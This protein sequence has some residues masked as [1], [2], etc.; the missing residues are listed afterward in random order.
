MSLNSPINIDTCRE[1]LEQDLLNAEAAQQ[2]REGAKEE[3]SHPAVA[4]LCAVC[5]VLDGDASGDATS[6]AARTFCALDR[7]R[8]ESLVVHPR[9]KQERRH[10]LASLFGR[11]LHLLEGDEVA[12]AIARAT[13]KAMP[14]TFPQLCGI[15]DECAKS[16]DVNA[17]EIRIARGEEVMFTVLVDKSPFLCV[18]R[19]FVSEGAVTT[20]LRLSAAE[21][22][23]AVAH[24]LE[25]VKSG[26][27]ALLQITPERLENLILDEIPFLVRTPIKVGSK[28][29]GWTRANK[30]VKKVGSWLPQKSRTQK[31]VNTVGE[32]L[33]D[34]A[35]ET[36]LP[37]VVHDWVRRWI[38][39]VE[40][41]A[42]RAG[43]LLSGSIAASCSAMLRLSPDYAPQVSDI[44]QRGARWLLREK[45][46]VDRATAERLR[47][48]LRFA[49]SEEYLSFVE[50]K[51]GEGRGK[52]G[53]E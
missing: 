47:E 8:H 16:L 34:A 38:Q 37:D 20:S 45:A 28:F 14:Q 25:H 6:F 33:P 40:F 51:E 35:Q 31:V 24:N 27:A 10:R 1:W 39:G 5:A 11:I 32:L 12:H 49:V 42:D 30:A 26:H 22:R 13:E 17:P 36:V 53:R 9:E 7:D 18:H 2:L 21:T 50:G 15:K 52:R 19:D 3:S 46:D 4:A 29:L 48:L 23:F 44:M 43:L 41:S